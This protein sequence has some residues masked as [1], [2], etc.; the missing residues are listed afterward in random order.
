[1]LYS[2]GNEIHDTPKPEIAIPI[3]RG[4]VKVCH[5]TD[6]TRPVTQA[7]FRPNK[8]GDYH[9]GLADLLD[10]IGTNYRDQELLQA[11]KD[12]PGRKIIGT[13]Q[14]HERSTWLACRDHPH[15][16][17]QFLWVGIDYLGESRRWPL[18]V[19]NAG[20]IDRAGFIQP[21]GWERQSWW[22]DAPMVKALR[23]VAPTAKT[24][25]D[26]GYEANEWKR[27]PVLFDDWTPKNPAPHEES[28]EVYSNA[29]EVG[30]FLNGKLLSWQK[31][32]K[33]AAPL[34]WK[35]PY[36]PGSLRAVAHIQG[37]EVAR[38]ELRSA[39][40]PAALRLISTPAQGS[41]WDDV[42]HVEVRI[43]DANGTIVPTADHLLQFE[44]SPDTD[45]VAA[46]GGDPY[47]VEPFL[48]QQHQAFQ[49]RCLAIIRSKNSGAPQLTVRTAGLP[50]A[51]LS[52]APKP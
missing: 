37:S 6:P 1:V 15:H 24:P 10:V 31:V 50:P 28:V 46:D 3:L 29:E 38:D 21:R 13:E 2:V 5:E 49:G 23:R 14:S 22:A 45:W 51:T 48:D 34:A 9:N 33:D 26:P 42:T 39:G 19:F 32:R 4:L 27:D 52:P 41:S 43:V 16:A 11:W 36:E 17:G 47:S 8:S 7:L 12:R 30:L 18:T 40:E 20:L 44:T 25:S 35:V